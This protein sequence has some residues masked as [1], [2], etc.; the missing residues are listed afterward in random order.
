MSQPT[1]AI[2]AVFPSFLYTLCYLLFKLNLGTKNLSFFYVYSRYP[3]ILITCINPQF[4]ILC[5][6]LGLIGKMYRKKLDL[7]RY[8]PIIKKMPYHP[9]FLGGIRELP[10]L[11]MTY[12]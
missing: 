1:P 8:S 7:Y 3:D 5:M 9:E 6:M 12:T 11:A 4:N 10:I 2:T